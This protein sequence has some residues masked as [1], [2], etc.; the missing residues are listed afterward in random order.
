MCGRYELN[1]TPAEITSIFG[2]RVP[3]ERASL[4]E[5]RPTDPAPVVL[6]GGEA[7]VLSW[8]LRAEWNKRPLINARAESLHAKPTFRRLLGRRC[9]VPCTAWFEWRKADG[10]KLKNRITLNRNIPFAL[11]GLH[12]EERFVIITR[13]AVD[14]VAHIH[15]RMP[16]V[17]PP[18]LWSAW[19]EATE[20]TAPLT[21]DPAPLR[22]EE[23][24]GVPSQPSLFG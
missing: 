12:D 15:D 2:L 6:A 13:A 23:E 20:D 10:R 11:A 8:G 5:V 18:E 14:A 17:L 16:A 7:R 22:A 24:G 9:L 19:L 4:P 1:L 3:P 21:A